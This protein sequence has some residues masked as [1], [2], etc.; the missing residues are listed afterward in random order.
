SADGKAS[1][2]TMVCSSSW[3]TA[4]GASPTM[5]LQKMQLGSCCLVIVSPAAHLGSA[6]AAALPRSRQVPAEAGQPVERD[7]GG[8][9]GNGE[10]ADVAGPHAGFSVAARM[11]NGAVVP[12]RKAKQRPAYWLDAVCW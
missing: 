1:M 6:Q 11:Q 9:T 4:A 2:K 3:T 8:W 10:P 7:G 5:I 12:R